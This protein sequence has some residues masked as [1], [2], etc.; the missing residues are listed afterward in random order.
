MAGDRIS[1]MIAAHSASDAL[2]ELL[3]FASEGKATDLPFNPEVDVVALLV[4]A[5]ARAAEIERAACERQGAGW[6]EDREA[7]SQLITACR[8]FQYDWIGA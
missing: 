6:E 8:R 1:A 5:L 2:A 7:L 4:E 3:R